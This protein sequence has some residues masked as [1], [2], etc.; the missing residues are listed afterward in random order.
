MRSSYRYKCTRTW[1]RIHLYKHIRTSYLYKHLRKP[2]LTDKSRHKLIM[3]LFGRHD[4][5]PLG[6]PLALQRTDELESN[7]KNWNPCMKRIFVPQEV[8]LFCCIA[9]L[10]IYKRTRATHEARSHTHTKSKCLQQTTAPIQRVRL[11]LI[12]PNETHPC[13]YEQDTHKEW[14]T[15]THASWPRNITW[16]DQVHTN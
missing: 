1:T 12:K 11:K 9:F 13:M 10:E 2:S 16:H 5:R 4:L 15:T 7:S 3:L 14:A 8:Q 6:R